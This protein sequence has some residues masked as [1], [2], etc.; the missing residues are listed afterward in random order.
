MLSAVIMAFS[1]YTKVPVPMLPPEKAERGMRNMLCAFPLT[2]IFIGGLYAA[3]VYIMRYY[4]VPYIACG[5]LMSVLPLAVNGGIHL[6]GYMDVSDAIA[7]YG[8]REKRISILKDPHVG[9]FAIIHAIIYVLL[10]V[11]AGCIIAEKLRYNQEMGSYWL[12]V[13]LFAFERCACALAAMLFPKMKK[14]GMLYAAVGDEISGMDSRVVVLGLQLLLLGVGLYICCPAGKAVMA[15][16]LLAGVYYY[17]FS[18]RNFGGVNG[19]TSG[20]YLQLAELCSM[21][22]V[23][24]FWL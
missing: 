16:Q 1:T 21:L 14:E 11:A 24:A 6:D 22:C 17:Y 12:F 13:L 10:Y 18:M 8:S 9:A 20:W 23:A 15:V 19:D 7:S 4:G 3:V 5:I 2:G